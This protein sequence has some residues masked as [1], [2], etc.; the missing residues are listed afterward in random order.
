MNYYIEYFGTAASVLVAISLT[1]K[2][3][4]RLRILNLVGAGAFSIYGFFIHAWPVFGLNLFITVIDL[5]YLI[6]ILRM[7]NYFEMMRIEEPSSSAY[8]KRFL[9]FYDEDIRK[10]IP[11]FKSDNIE[12]MKAVFILRDV[13]PVSLVIYDENTAEVEILLDYA[14]P[15]YRDMKN[16]KYF[17]DRIAETL[18]EENR[19]FVSKT[20]SSIHNKYLE[21]L[22]FCYSDDKGKYILG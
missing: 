22:G 4:K 18:K 16:A 7:K 10:F 9:E 20:G 1:Q 17:F 3:I 13:L 11:D 19:S 2:N 14:I 12:G 8:L 21:K 15:S 6:E 5:Y